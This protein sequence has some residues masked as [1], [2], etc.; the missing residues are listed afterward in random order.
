MPDREQLGIMCLFGLLAI[1]YVLA[2][3]IR[4]VIEH[5]YVVVPTVVGLI[6]LRV[7]WR[8]RHPLY[9]DDEDDFAEPVPQE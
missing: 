4:F 6:S 3:I 9:L 7:W 2:L 8:R 5:W 1:L